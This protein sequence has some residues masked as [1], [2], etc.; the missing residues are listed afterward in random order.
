MTIYQNTTLATL[1]KPENLPSPGAVIAS[2]GQGEVPKEKQEVLLDLVEKNGADLTGDQKDKFYTLLINYSS[3]FATTDLE[4]GKTNKLHHQI[5]TGNATPIRQAVRRICSVRREEVRGLL[6]QMQEKDVIQQSSSPWASLIVLVKKKD[7][8][9]RFCVDYRKLNNV[10]RKDAYPLPRID[11]TLDTLSGSQWFSTLDLVSGYWQVEIDEKDQPKTAFCTTEGLYEFKVMPFGLCNAPATFQRLMD[12]VLAGLQWSHCLVYIDDV[13]ILGRDY[14]DHLQ[15]LQVVFERLLQAG[16]KLK[17]SKCAFF[18]QQVQYLGHLISPSGVRPDPTKTEKVATWPKPTS[19][20][21]VQQFLG[22][23]NYYRRFIKDFAQIAKPLHQLTERGIAFS[24]SKDCEDFFNVLRD[25]LSGAPLLVFPNF[26]KPFILDTD[27]SDIGIGAVLSQADEE[28]RERV[29]AYGSRLLSKSE[30]KY[31]VTRREL[32]AVVVF[33]KQFR[34]YLF[35]HKFVLRTDHGSITWLRN[36]KEPEGQLARWLEKLQEFNFEVVHR[37]GRKHTN[38][39]ALSRLPCSQC[40]R[41]SHN[42]EPKAVLAVSFSPDPSAEELSQLQRDDPTIGPV[43][44]AMTTGKRPDKDELKQFSLHTNRLFALWDQLVLQDSVL[45][46]HFISADGIQDCLQLIAPKSQHQKILEELH[47]GAVAGHLGEEKTLNRL[48]QRFYWPGH[49]N[50]VRDFCRTCPVCIATKTP[51]PKC[52]AELKP[53]K[54]GYPMQIV[55]VDILGPLPE[56]DAGNSYL[57]VVG[58][59][60]TRWMEAFPIPNQEAVTVARTLIDKYF[61]RFGLP[62]QLHSDQGKQFVSDLLKEVCRVLRIAKSR[63]TAY[64]PQSDGLVER[65]NRTL[66]SMLSTCANEHP[67]KWE[68]Y[69]QKVCMAYNTSIQATTEYTPYYLMFGREARLPIDCMFEC[70]TQSTVATEYAGQLSTS[71]NAAYEM[72][73]EKVGLKQNRQK[74]AYDKRIH[75]PF[76]SPGDLVLLHNTRVP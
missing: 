13:I 17:P 51:P 60:F 14:D 12:L 61:C 69:V 52:R 40:K 10:T 34:P 31:C 38:A 54:P 53:I 64:H 9:T 30:R 5:E 21:S 75:G 74:E 47:S 29:V 70:P 28:G 42:A 35:G 8:T 62:E 59:Y 3:I 20:R 26:N 67:F 48:R 15:N 33:T 11:S 72:V 45:Y 19:T 55:A 73:R 32:L 58:E 43:L 65:Y 44:Q 27:A 56:S 36:F 46:R 66:L 63:T 7:G 22:F 24:W 37:R 4:L 41:D 1:E 25:C 23:A 68:D 49:F 18:Q 16:L 2:A 57:L 76:H 39:D 6:K 50:D 71:L